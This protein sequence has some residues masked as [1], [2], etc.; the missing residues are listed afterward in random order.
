MLEGP[1]THW[2][3]WQSIFPSLLH[4]GEIVRE[5][6]TPGLVQNLKVGNSADDA[7]QE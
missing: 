6:A 1:W 2:F 5:D 3:D 7:K 4:L